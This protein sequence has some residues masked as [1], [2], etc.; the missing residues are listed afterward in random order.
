MNKEVVAIYRQIYNEH[1]YYNTCIALQMPVDPRV[2][3]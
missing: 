1:Y 2:D 3:I